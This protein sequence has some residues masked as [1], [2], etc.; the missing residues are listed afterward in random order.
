MDP[1]E[2]ED[3][4]NRHSGRCR[5]DDVVEMVLAG[6]DC[7]D[8]YEAAQWLNIRRWLDANP[9]DELADQT[10]AELSAA[11]ARH[12]RYRREYLGWGVV[13]LMNR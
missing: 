4:R 6:Q 1:K 12:A 8:R 13:V 2:L 9:H 3:D 5:G 11:P 7:W 10:R